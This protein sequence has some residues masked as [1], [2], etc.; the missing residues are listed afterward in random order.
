MDTDSVIKK[1]REIST[2]FDNFDDV[3]VC[4]MS[5]ETFTIVKSSY[6]YPE[7]I[8]KENHNYGTT[9]LANAETKN[10]IR[11]QLKENA[12]MMTMY[13]HILLLSSL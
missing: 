8:K 12:S 11:K 9:N 6:M 13:S 7:K 2:I 3:E 10:S 1:V 4:C 5:C